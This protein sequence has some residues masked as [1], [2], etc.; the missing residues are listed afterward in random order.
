MH[1]LLPE[2]D[3]LKAFSSKNQYYILYKWEMSTLRLSLLLM[4]QRW[5][6]VFCFFMPSAKESDVVLQYAWA[7]ILIFSHF[8][9]VWFYSLIYWQ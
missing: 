5:R 3:N 1:C 6:L 9:L 2:E 8:Y 4:Y 7:E